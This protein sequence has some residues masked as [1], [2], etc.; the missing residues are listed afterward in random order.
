MADSNDLV[1]LYYLGGLP[2]PKEGGMLY[3]TS[4]GEVYTVPPVGEYIKVPRSTAR[5]IIRRTRMITPT[6]VYMRF[7][8]DPA[9]AAQVKNRKN[10]DATHVN[11]DETI[12]ELQKRIKQLEARIYEKPAALEVEEEALESSENDEL[13]TLET[14]TAETK[15]VARTTKRKRG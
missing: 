9:I 6:A 14:Y 4:K 15:P 13:V 10:L 12:E 8:E 2:A 11:K 3:V 5:N 1:K 7:T